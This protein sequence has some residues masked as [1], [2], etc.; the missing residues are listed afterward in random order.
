MKREEENEENKVAAKTESSIEVQ[1][2]K[3]EHSLSS[4]H[5]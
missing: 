5:E 3:H 4:E 2:L 1:K